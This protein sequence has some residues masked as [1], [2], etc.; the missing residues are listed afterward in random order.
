MSM[1]AEDYID[2]EDFELPYVD[3]WEYFY[4]KDYNDRRQDITGKYLF[5]SKHRDVLIRIARE[6][7]KRNFPLAKII[8]DGYQRS[9]EYVMCLYYYDDSLKYLL[10]DEYSWRP[11][12]KYRYWKS[13]FDTICGKYSKQL[14]GLIYDNKKR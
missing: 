6:K 10:A 13:N 11:C 9:D 4:G 3:P 5:F 14:S 12:V 2:F 8:K 7:V 1:V